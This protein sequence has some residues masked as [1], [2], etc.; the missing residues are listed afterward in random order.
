M[1]T[2][3]WQSKLQFLFQQKG[4]DQELDFKSNLSEN[5]ERL[6]E[7]INAMANNENGGMFVLGVGKDFSISTEILNTDQLTRHLSS[8]ARDTQEPALTVQIHELSYNGSI[9]LGIEIIPPGTRPVFIKDRAPLGGQACFKRSGSSTVVMRIAEVRELLAKSHQF[10]PDEEIVQ[11]ASLSDINIVEMN[12]KFPQ[13]KSSLGLAENNLKILEDNK[14]IRKSGGGDW[15]PTLAGWLM[16][17]DNPQSQRFLKNASIV[18]QQF[19]GKTREDQLKKQEISGNLAQQVQ[20]AITIVSQNIWK[21]PKLQGVRRED[22]PAYDD[23][24]LREVIIN[25]VVHRDYRQLQ[26]PVKIAMF[27]D[28][29]EIENPGGLLPGLTPLNLMNK[30]E[31]RNPNIANLMERFGLGEMDGQGIDRIYEATRRLKVPAPQFIDDKNTFKVILSAPKAYENYLPEE[32]KLTVL[33]LLI[34][35]NTIDNESIRNSFGIDLIK[36][37]TLLKSLVEDGLIVKTGIG[38]YAKYIL[39]PEWKRKIE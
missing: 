37:S 34:I 13:F 20:E 16:F 38:R 30:R 7:H 27:I 23:I 26:Q 29:I 19:K 21:V 9:L 2:A 25:S 11:N 32:K 36:A 15:A 14:V 22:I 24:T 1:K 3:Y 31:W 18:F 12:S 4:E 10:N 17:A 6:K 8:L 35:E 5:K 28:R 39:S 33:I